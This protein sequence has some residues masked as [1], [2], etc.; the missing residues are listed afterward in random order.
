VFVPDLD[1]RVGAEALVVEVS[2]DGG[3]DGELFVVLLCVN[4]VFD[5]GDDDVDDLV[6]HVL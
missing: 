1:G 3:P 4:G 5:I 6:D 2:E